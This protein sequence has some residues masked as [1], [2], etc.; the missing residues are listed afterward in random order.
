MWIVS[1]IGYAQSDSRIIRA[2]GSASMGL[3]GVTRRA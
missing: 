2:I 1:T 3:A